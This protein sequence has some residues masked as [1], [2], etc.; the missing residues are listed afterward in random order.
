[1]LLSS[2]ITMEETMVQNLEKNNVDKKSSK[3]T[4]K[5]SK[6]SAKTANHTSTK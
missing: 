5:D 1:M 2:V 4:T 3:A 6:Q